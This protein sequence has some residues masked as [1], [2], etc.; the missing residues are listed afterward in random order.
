MSKQLQKR[1]FAA[2]LCGHSPQTSATVPLGPTPTLSFSGLHLPLHSHQRSPIHA[3]L[4]D[5]IRE[6][7]YTPHTPLLCRIAAPLADP[8]PLPVSRVTSP[9]SITSYEFCLP[10]HQKPLSDAH[11][12]KIPYRC[13]I[14]PPQKVHSTLS[15]ASHPGQQPTPL[16]VPAHA[17]A[18]QRLRLPT[19][20]QQAIAVRTGTKKTYV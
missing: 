11:P 12:D 15:G 5:I 9:L 4:T 14:S 10:R 8:H 7:R 13:L 18:F 6:S 1:K 3:F 2:V 16:S 17:I 19:P 20:T